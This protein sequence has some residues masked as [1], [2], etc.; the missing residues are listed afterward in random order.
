[1]LDR[2]EHL[3]NPSGMDGDHATRFMFFDREFCREPAVFHLVRACL[4]DVA[5]VAQ[6]AHH[7]ET[8]R[9]NYRTLR[10]RRLPA[11]PSACHESCPTEEADSAELPLPGAR[12]PRTGFGWSSSSRTPSSYLVLLPRA[13]PKVLNLAF[14]ESG[15]VGS[16]RWSFSPV[17]EAGAQSSTARQC[18]RAWPKAG[19]N[20]TPPRK[21]RFQ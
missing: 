11:V 14:R 17:F 20:R 15:P 8:S 18:F 6:P 7:A 13:V 16:W 1:M 3:R 9:H 21:A 4:N 19:S 12:L 2:T 5:L 10:L